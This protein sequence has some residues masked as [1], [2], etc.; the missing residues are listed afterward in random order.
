MGIALQDLI[1]LSKIWNENKSIGTVVVKLLECFADVKKK[2]MS[3]KKLIEKLKD[4][5]ET[6]SGDGS[7]AQILILHSSD[8]SIKKYQVI[9]AKI[10]DFVSE[11]DGFSLWREFVQ[12]KDTSTEFEEKINEFMREFEQ[13][14]IAVK[15]VR[16]IKFD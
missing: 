13:C 14:Q 3:N 4:C 5:A 7:L 11:Y 6:A 8:E 16:I 1:L 10:I 15:E 9:L 12:A 2:K